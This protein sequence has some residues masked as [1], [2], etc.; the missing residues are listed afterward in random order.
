[1]EEKIYT[2][3]QIA[4]YFIKK[5]RE[6]SDK[7]E[8]TPLKLQKI[9]YYAQGWYLANFDKPLFNDEIQAW[10][11]GPVVPSVY[12]TFKQHGSEDLSKIVF[13]ND[14]IKSIESNNELK[15]FLDEVWKVYK[16]YDG[17]DLIFSTHREAPW[18]DAYELHDDGNCELVIGVDS[19]KRFFKN[20]LANASQ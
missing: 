18:K 19:M 7:K 17:T 6:G 3:E 15:H 1:M 13:S 5:A 8:L 9:L 12:Q 14:D 11:Y 2:A 16:K 20:K 4:K 10:K